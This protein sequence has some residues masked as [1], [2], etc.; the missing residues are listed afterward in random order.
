MLWALRCLF[1]INKHEWNTRSEFWPF[2]S[3]ILL[4][5]ESDD[6]KFH[7]KVQWIRGCPVDKFDSLLR[8]VIQQE[9]Q[10]HPMGDP[11]LNKWEHD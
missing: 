7:L 1:E 3:R 8:W 11:A 10:S 2:V 6:T 4:N 5:N 9:P